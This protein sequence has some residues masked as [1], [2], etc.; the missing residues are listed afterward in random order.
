MK[1]SDEIRKILEN[2]RNISSQ[3]IVI[4]DTAELTFWCDQ[5]LNILDETSFPNEDRYKAL[6]TLYAVLRH[7]S[8]IGED[9]PLRSVANTM[10]ELSKNTSILGPSKDLIQKLEHFAERDYIFRCALAEI[11]NMSGEAAIRARKALDELN[12]E[13]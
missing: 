7:Q 8:E 2:I 9:F 4:L 12:K 1:S 6:E 11:A 13:R 5:A 10:F 3:G